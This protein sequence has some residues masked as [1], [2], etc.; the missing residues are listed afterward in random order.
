MLIF[1]VSFCLRAYPESTASRKR[2]IYI[3]QKTVLK[4]LGIFTLVFFVMSMTG[5]AACSSGACNSCTKSCTKCTSTTSSA[6]CKTD[7]KNDVFTLNPCKSIKCFNVLKN[8]KGCNLKVVT[9]GYITTAKKG[10]VLMKSSGTFCYSKPVS[11]S[12]GSDSF[13]YR[14]VNNKGQYD[15][16]T[17]TLKFTCY[18]CSSCSSGS[19]SSCTSGKCPA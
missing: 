4:T 14:A 15:T 11:C 17:V 19:C 7:A 2:R 5:A 9:T 10:K 12:M 18:G 1:L 8:D 3:M 6:S 16:A 13:T